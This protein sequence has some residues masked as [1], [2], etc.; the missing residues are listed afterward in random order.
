MGRKK[1]PGLINRKGIWH[2]DKQIRGR[3]VCESTGTGSLEEAEEY[4][5][6]RIEEIRKAEVYGQRPRRSWRKAATKY[7]NES[8]KK[9]LRDAADQIRLL[10]PYIGDLPIES[11]HMGTLKPFIDYRKKQGRKMRTINYALQTV[12]HILNLAA[13]EWIDEY[14][15]TWLD[16][17]PKIKLLPQKDAR[18]P[19]PIT[20]EEQTKL[21]AELP[22]HLAKMA[23]FKVNTGCREAEVCGLR[24][25][26]EVFVPEMDASL[27][28]VPGSGVKNGE[29]RLIVLNRYARAVVQEMRGIH[30][31]YVFTYQRRPIKKMYGG[32]W[33][34]ARERAGLPDLR[35]HDL[36]HTFGRRLRAAGVSYED[37]QDLLGHKS[38]R[39]TTH[40]SNAELLN[41]IEAA[42]KVCFDESRKS[43]A[44]V[45][46][47]QKTAAPAMAS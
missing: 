33:R 6:H 42:D 34:K 24:W 16:H 38:G 40:Y 17:A 25:E 45:I 1:T 13:G 15:Q 21:L 31:D 29:D 32:A 26:W 37:R 35:V 7:L 36:K 18:P 4:L 9:T 10:D 5:A 39:M 8:E 20:W 43:P 47:R 27:F 28:I 11:V 23:L 44:L 30:P 41:L 3:R 19:Y 22:E 12:R 14:G 46:L 2:I